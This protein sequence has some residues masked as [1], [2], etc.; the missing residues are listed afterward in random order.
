MH[1]S[2]M[3]FS[4]LPGVVLLLLFQGAFGFVTVLRKLPNGVL[5]S[6]S[7]SYQQARNKHRL[8]QRVDTSLVLSSVNSNTDDTPLEFVLHRH[9]G[10]IEAEVPI[11]MRLVTMAEAQARRNYLVKS[12]LSFWDIAHLADGYKIDGRGY[13]GIIQKEDTG[14]ETLGCCIITPQLLSGDHEM[15][16]KLE[17]ILAIKSVHDEEVLAAWQ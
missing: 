6:N 10:S 14:G 11:G 12:L 9:E 13:G 7:A 17:E 4:L 8:E 15:V 16:K 1:T 2:T 5:V 3:K